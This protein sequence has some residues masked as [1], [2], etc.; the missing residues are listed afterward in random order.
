MT[1]IIDQ[2]DLRYRKLQQPDIRL[3]LSGIIISR[4]GSPPIQY[5]I[6]PEI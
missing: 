4:V 2:V 1:I 3:Q 6:K 5:I